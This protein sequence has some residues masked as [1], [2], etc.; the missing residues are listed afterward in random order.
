MTAHEFN[1]VKN[2]LLARR[3]RQ[4]IS[5]A[6]EALYSEQFDAMD[7]LVASFSDGKGGSHL[8]RAYIAISVAAR[9]SEPLSDADVEGAVR[10]LLALESHVNRAHFDEVL[11]VYKELAE[12]HWQRRHMAILRGKL[13]DQ[14]D[15]DSYEGMLYRGEREMRGP[16]TAEQR[17]KTREL[18]DKLSD[19]GLS[20]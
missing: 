8:L 9:M 5:E 20:S 16:A 17:A 12:L 3:M 10:Q 4:L 7:A 15:E 11:D 13:A 6:V 14:R 18:A 19:P 1:L 2:P